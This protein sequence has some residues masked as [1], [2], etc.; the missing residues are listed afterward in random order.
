MGTNKPLIWS[1]EAIADL[2][3]IWDFYIDATGP[4]TAE[5]V[6]REIAETCRIVEAHP[7]AGRTRDEVRPGLRSLDSHRNVIFYRVRD[8][9]SEIVRV[10]DGRRDID[11]I[12]DN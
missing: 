3:S 8:D 9:G 5:N 12:F 2:E 1:Q 10:L 11:A 7:L 6:V 4:R